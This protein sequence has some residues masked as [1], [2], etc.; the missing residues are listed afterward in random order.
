MRNL[1]FSAESIYRDSKV[2]EMVHGMTGEYSVCSS[3]ALLVLS[4]LCISEASALSYSS[5][6]ENTYH[7]ISSKAKRH[8]RNNIFF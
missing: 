7:I 5:P 6:I 4:V 1:W 3:R 2:I 8:V